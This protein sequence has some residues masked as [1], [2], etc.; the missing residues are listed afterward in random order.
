MLRKIN[1]RSSQEIFS[2]IYEYS[3]W[4]RSSNLLQPFY[5]GE[6]SDDGEIVSK[7]V[8]AVTGFLKQFKTKPDV[9]DLGC[10]NFFVGSKIRPFCGSYTACDIVPELIEHNKI[11]YKDL[12]V[13]FKVL[14]ISV[15][16]LPKGDIMFVRQVLQHLSNEE[17]IKFISKIAS[18]CNFLI[19]TEH[20]PK[21][22]FKANINKSTGSNI[23]LSMNSGVLITAPPF[24]FSAKEEFVLC[25]V[26]DSGG[27]I[28]TIIYS[29]T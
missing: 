29:I 26:Q 4:G 18:S 28:K 21:N 27:V 23:R 5:S 15:D 20:L 25:E 7:Y 13:N 11:A 9:I 10:G 8:E 19:L 24:N 17:I 16:N 6:G 1:D 2:N 22:R 12:D 3:L 14:D